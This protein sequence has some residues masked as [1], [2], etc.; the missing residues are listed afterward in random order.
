MEF[1]ITLIDKHDVYMCAPKSA[2]GFSHIVKKNVC[3]FGCINDK[4][5]QLSLHIN[6]P[7]VNK[8]VNFKSIKSSVIPNLPDGTYDIVIS[9]N[10]LI[11]HIDHEQA[12]RE[13]EKF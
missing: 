4:K 12:L 8:D 1:L 5:T 11:Y 10:E 6:T 3:L 9:T 2:T 7:S 13:K